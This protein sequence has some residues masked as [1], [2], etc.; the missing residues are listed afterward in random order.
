M[1]KDSKPINFLMLFMFFWCLIPLSAYSQKDSISVFFK[2]NQSI[3]S[4]ESKAILDLI[5]NVNG[6]NNVQL[7]GYCD[8]TGNKYS[9]NK[10]AQNRINSVYKYLSQYINKQITFSVF[11]KGESN[12]LV[13]NFSDQLSVNRRV[14]IIINRSIKLLH[15]NLSERFESL[16]NL[17]RGDKI[18][19]PNLNF[20]PGTHHILKQSQSTLEK[21]AVILKQYPKIKIELQGH[22]CCI[23]EGDG[24]DP[25]TG[26][27]DLSVNRAREVY[28][29]LIQAGI[30]STRLQFRGFGSSRKI[31]E[32][33]TE[34]NKSINRRVEIVILDN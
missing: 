17:K 26:T 6:I 18:K 10:L 3:L 32:E 34:F 33:T 7:F 4:I 12:L 27:N 25:E 23:S 24:P 9:N 14:D 22:I 28:N 13:K 21:L 15:T 30:D 2:H 11:P 8:T 5:A 31:V 19:I 29:Y 1:K 16:A 20:Q